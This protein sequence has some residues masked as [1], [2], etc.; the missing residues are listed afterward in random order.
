MLRIDFLRHGELVGGIKYRG[1]LDEALTSHGRESMDKVW[2]TLENEVGLVMSSPLSRCAEPA[3]AWSEKTKV[4]CVFDDRIQELNYGAWEGLTHQEI[5]ECTPQLLQQWR[6][7][8]T[9]LTPPK[10]E[11]M[12]S[13]A[14]RTKSFLDDLIQTQEENHILVVAHSG[15]IRLMLAH[16]LRAPIQSTRHLAM[17]YACWSRV[18]V[19]HQQA[20]LIFHSRNVD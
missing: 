19:R 8:P 12:Q 2:Q 4:S 11:S 10:G 13:F 5:K 15:S 6:E 14:A 20:Q 3:L 9:H 17:P 1:C 16:L 18:E 7:D